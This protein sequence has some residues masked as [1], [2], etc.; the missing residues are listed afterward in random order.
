MAIEWTITIEG[1][2]EF[3]EVCRRQIQIDKSWERLRDG[4]IG[5][6]IGDGKTI[7]KSLQTAVVTQEMETYALFRR[8]C[9]D[10]H[11]FRPVKDYTK[12]RIRT[13]FGTV[14]VKNPRWMLCE[15]CHPG[16]VAGFTV[17]KEICPDRATPELMELTARLGS[18]LPYRQAASVLAEFLPVEPTETH[19]TVRKRTIKIGGLL[20]DQLIEEARRL[21]SEIDNRYQ[22]EMQLP[23]DRRKE[24]VISVDTAHV[25]SA[26]PNMARNFEI[27]VARCG[28]GGRGDLNGRYFVTSNTD[29]SEIRDRA[30]KPFERP[31]TAA[32][33]TSP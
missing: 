23:G 32:L 33:G 31:A 27:V 19:A 20:D 15:D 2:N 14:E 25:R 7:M 6:S 4:E 18:M 3:G 21:R 5:L 28:P 17:L 26:D 29:Q 22:L 30:C 16:M 12:R 1:R 9:P 24:F 11:T 10:C 13:V 8:V